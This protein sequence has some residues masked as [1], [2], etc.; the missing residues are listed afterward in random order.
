M[1][2]GKEELRLQ[3]ELRLLADLQTGDYP[4]LLWAQTN[5]KGVLNVEGFRKVSFRMMR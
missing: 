5:N 3:K 2:C 1:L 4:G